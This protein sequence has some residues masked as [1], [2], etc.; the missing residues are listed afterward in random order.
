MYTFKLKDFL[1]SIFLRMIIKQKLSSQVT[2]LLSY[3]NIAVTQNPTLFFPHFGMR[4]GQSATFCN[5]HFPQI[6]ERPSRA[7]VKKNLWDT[8]LGEKQARCSIFKSLFVFLKNAMTSRE[9][10][11]ET[12]RDILLFYSQNISGRTLKTLTQAREQCQ[13]D[14]LR[15]TSRSLHSYYLRMRN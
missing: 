3:L 13:E 4:D 6:Q 5:S 2:I 11:K 8:L 9:T 7:D 14:R 1:P 10:E 12:G 15:H